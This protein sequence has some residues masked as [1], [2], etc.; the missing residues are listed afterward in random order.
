MQKIW[1][2]RTHNERLKN[3]LSEN[4]NI[5]PVLAQLLIN[6]NICDAEEA[7]RFLF[8]DIS[9]CYDPFL[10]KGMNEAV[11]RIKKAI[12]NKEKFLIY[13]DYDVDGI[14]SVALLKIILDEMG[15]AVL[16][17]IP[18]RLEEGYGLNTKAVRF[19]K[20]K[21]IALIITADCG[22][23]AV[24]EVDL[25]NSLGIDVIVTD[26][27]EIKKDE[28]PNAFAVI[29]PHQKGC[30]YPFKYL[31]GV[32]IIYKLSQALMKK[33]YY[34]IEN[35]LDLVALGTVADIAPQKSENRIF[36]KAGLSY[37]NDTRKVGLKSLIAV[38]GLGK[39]DISSSHIGYILGPRINAMGRIG[40]ADIALKLLLTDNKLE[41]DK[42]A[43]ILNSENKNRQKIESDILDEAIL[44]V[45]R[46]VNFKEE[47]VIVLDKEGWHPGVIGIVASRIQERY[48][49]P[50]ILVAVKDNIAKGSGRGIDEFNLFEA[51]MASKDYLIDFGGHEMACGLSMHKKDIDKFRRA[52]NSYAREKISDK[53]LFP[54]I[55]IDIHM[56]LSDLSM[57][58]I[59]ELDLL[60]PYGPENPRPV[61]LSSRVMLREEPR[62]IGKNGIKMWITSGAITCEAINFRK[63]LV[64]IPK[65][66]QV[67]DI[68]YSPA[69]NSWQG[70]DSIQL[71]LFD[72]KVRD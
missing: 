24:E 72:I 48:Y 30:T 50:T 46:E 33:R 18:N 51:L 43:N 12:E 69:I 3:Y 44:K 62:Q 13:G 16:T 27:H 19:A 29:N 67:F 32:G 65:T 7:Q 15:A 36:T 47:R 60:R 49:R 34:H 22:I 1:N 37:L 17:Y 39:R 10:L 53:D 20:D 9:S 2:L 42:L 35:H 55:E 66:G 63:G 57:S 52:I 38:S 68:A 4:L 28:M 31:A 11:S 59:N 70:I 8:G 14:T 21:D 58:V 61:F 64:N 25:A 71:D 40:S 26:H 45:E 5:S 41:A 56:P 54:K 6:R 23:G